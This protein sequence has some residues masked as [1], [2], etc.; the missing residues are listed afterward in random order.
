MAAG[1]L[2]YSIISTCNGLFVVTRQVDNRFG[3]KVWEAG[4]FPDSKDPG[5]KMWYSHSDETGSEL[6]FLA[7]PELIKHFSLCSVSSL[8]SA[9]GRVI[10]RGES[11]MMG[12]L[13][14]VETVMK[15][16]DQHPSRTALLLDAPTS[17]LRRANDMPVSP[18]FQIK[19]RILISTVCPCAFR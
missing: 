2:N 4:R 19:T 6:R 14:S 17:A 13:P 12:G 9:T 11:Q 5:L 1:R 8:V 10:G 15:H 18:L 7:P 3:F 16:N